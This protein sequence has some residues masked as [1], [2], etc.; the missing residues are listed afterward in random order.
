M[1]KNLEILVYSHRDFFTEKY[2]KIWKNLEKN[3]RFCIL[4]KNF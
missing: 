1:G 2:W 4:S 3:C